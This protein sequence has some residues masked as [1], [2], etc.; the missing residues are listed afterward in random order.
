[1]NQDCLATVLCAG[2][3]QLFGVNHVLLLLL[4]L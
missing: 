4:L 3:A 1:M 2:A